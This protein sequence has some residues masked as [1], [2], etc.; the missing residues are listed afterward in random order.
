MFRITSI[1]DFISTR[2][3][4][5]QRIAALVTLLALSGIAPYI[6]LQ[7]TAVVSSFSIITGSHESEAW[8]MT[9]LLVM[10][11]M[12]VFTIMFGIRRLDPTERHSG[13]IAVLV[14]E[15]LVKLFALL[16]VGFF[17]LRSVFGD[18]QGLFRNPQS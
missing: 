1:A 11:M 12:L 17:I 10:V 7:L 13:M 18:F 2:Y 9:G 16:I 3:R 8:D 6:S 5:S 4:R 14:A 15:C